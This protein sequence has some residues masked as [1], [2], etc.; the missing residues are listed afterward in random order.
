MEL[1]LAVRAQ[2]LSD[3]KN[4]LVAANV[5]VLNSHVDRIEPAIRNLAEGLHQRGVVPLAAAARPHMC[6]PSGGTLTRRSRQAHE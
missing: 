5:N 4:A 1:Y 3:A 6:R 2:K